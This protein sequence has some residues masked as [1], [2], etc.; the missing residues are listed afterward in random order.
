MALSDL[1][2]L[3]VEDDNFSR[4]V[5]DVLCLDVL[6]IQKFTT[7]ED[8]ENFLERALA[9][10]EKPN[11]IFLDIQM[12]PVDGYEMLKQ[13][14]SCSDHKETTVIALTANVMAHDVDQL[15]NV[16]FD[17]L[18]GKPIMEEVFAEQIET[19]ANG[20]PVWYIP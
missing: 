11:L 4:K 17:G 10:P 9:L 16:G 14:R 19:I 20:D 13:L 5:M 8:S 1:I 6:G 7:F 3:Y 2:I 18:I 12:R 15:K